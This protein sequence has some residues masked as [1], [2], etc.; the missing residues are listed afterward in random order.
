MKIKKTLVI[1]ALC[2]MALPLFAAEDKFSQEYLQSKNHFSL[3]KPIVESAVEKGIKKALKKETGAKFDVDFGGYTTASIKKGIF[4]HIELSADDVTVNDLTIPYLH[5]KSISDYNYIDYTQDPI[6][7]K[8]DMEFAYDMILDEDVI[9]K[10]LK[11]DRYLNVIGMINKLAYPIL[12]ANSVKTK[13]EKNRMFI[14]IA[15]NLPVISLREKTCTIS[16]DFTAEN[17]VIKAKHVR[18]EKMKANISLDKIANMVNLLNPL[19]FTMKLLET[20]DIRGNIENVNI[21]DNKVKING[22]IFI[23][24]DQ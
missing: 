21:V 24:G 19:D 15:Y 3:T 4:K 12:S 20:K 17:G 10:A 13:F 6:E 7:F 22:K 9:N 16:C 11:D 18:I 1:I 14:D 8:S 2:S 23:K 5:L